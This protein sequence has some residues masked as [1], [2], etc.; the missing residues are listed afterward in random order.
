MTP[1]NFCFWLQGFFEISQH[2]DHRQGLTSEA[3]EEIR[4]HLKT[5]FVKVTPEVKVTIDTQK[6]VD[7][8]KLLEA[9][10]RGGFT[11]HPWGIGKEPVVTC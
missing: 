8:S 9:I 3:V 6:V 10:R 11:G 7:D 5:V 2:I 4:N 1:E